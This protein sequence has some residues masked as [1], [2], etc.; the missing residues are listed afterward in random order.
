M[1]IDAIEFPR[2]PVAERS[3]SS[4]VVWEGKQLGRR[5][6]FPDACG[7]FRINM[8]LHRKQAGGRSAAP[9]GF[10]ASRTRL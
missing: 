5:T 6:E 7:T 8:V 2:V 4:N 10:D 9:T 3:R 1:P